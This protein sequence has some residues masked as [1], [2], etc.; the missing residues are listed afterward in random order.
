MNN[1]YSFSSRNKICGRV[2]A[3][4]FPVRSALH[5]SVGPDTLTNMFVVFLMFSRQ[6]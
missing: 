3:F 5:T 2:V 1:S 4:V 6:A